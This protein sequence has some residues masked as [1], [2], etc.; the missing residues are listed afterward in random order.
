MLDP[1]VPPLPMNPVGV[2]PNEGRDAEF[3]NADAPSPPPNAPPVGCPPPDV[4]IEARNG[5]AAPARPVA[6]GRRPTPVVSP[7]ENGVVGCA[8]V[9]FE[10]SALVLAFGDTL[11]D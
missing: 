6:C 1:G 7:D 3:P 8:P 4:S 5:L 2:V 9:G 11:G 10:F